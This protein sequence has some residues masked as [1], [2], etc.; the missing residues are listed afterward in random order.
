MRFVQP[1]RL[2]FAGLACI[3]LAM[4]QLA[5]AESQIPATAAPVM[6][7]VHLQAGGTLAGNVVDSEGTPTPDALVAVWYQDRVIAETRTNAD[8]RFAVNGLRGGMHNVVAGESLTVCRFWTPNT[9][10]PSATA[11]VLIVGDPNVVRGNNCNPCCN[12]CQNRCQQRCNP[13]ANQCAQQCCPCPPPCN[14]Y[15]AHNGCCDPGRETSP[16]GLGRGSAPSQ[17]KR[18]LQNPVVIGGLIAT[19]IAVPVA[20]NSSDKSGS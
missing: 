3:N 13:C 8:G 5:R 6:I 20:L 19:A 11:E 7:D 9:A 1:S 17:L 15:T 4:P 18:L 12:P 10:P 14:S 2:L 16:Y